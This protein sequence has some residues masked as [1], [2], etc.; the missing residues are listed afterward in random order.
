MSDATW[1]I[2]PA[3]PSRL[4]GSTEGAGKYVVGN[5]KTGRVLGSPKATTDQ[6]GDL[7]QVMAVALVAPDVTTEPNPNTWLLR[8]QAPSTDHGARGSAPC[9]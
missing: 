3:D 7:D 1:T 2:T 8:E 5:F 4:F 6:G 9:A